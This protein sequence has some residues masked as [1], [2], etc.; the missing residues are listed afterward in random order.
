MTRAGEKLYGDWERCIDK[1]ARSICGGRAPYSVFLI[2]V[3]VVVRGSA[4]FG[5]C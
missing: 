3:I 1:N 5:F 4:L 2:A